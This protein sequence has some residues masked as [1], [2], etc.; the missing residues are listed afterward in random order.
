VAESQA[1]TAAT[2]RTDTGAGA[3]ARTS[4]GTMSESDL[5]AMAQFGKTVEELT[6]DEFVAFL[7][8]PGAAQFVTVETVEISPEDEA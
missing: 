6:E 8:M 7:K 3:R 2:S 1:G 5:A 4:P